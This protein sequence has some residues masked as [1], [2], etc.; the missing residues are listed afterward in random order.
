MKSIHQMASIAVKIRFC[1]SPKVCFWSGVRLVRVVVVA[2]FAC[3]QPL[4]AI[5]YSKL[6]MADIKK[7]AKAGDKDAQY[8]LGGLYKLGVEIPKDEDAAKYW[9]RKAAEQG[10]YSAWVALGDKRIAR[11]EPPFSLPSSPENSPAGSQLP[12]FTAAAISEAEFDFLAGTNPTR[13]PAQN[14][15]ERYLERLKW[16]NRTYFLSA[17]YIPTH[18]D[19]D[20]LRRKTLALL[21]LETSE[22]A[23]NVPPVL[24]RHVYEGI[25]FDIAVQKLWDARLNAN[26]QIAPGL[27][28]TAREVINSSGWDEADRAVERNLFDLAYKYFQLA[29][30]W[31]GLKALKARRDL[32]TSWARA[33]RQLSRDGEIGQAGKLYAENP[34]VTDPTWQFIADQ[35]AGDA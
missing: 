18:T 11:P 23:K 6:S 28:K 2:F 8:A 4:L 22:A 7:A 21:E 32:H 17:I 5:D 29:Q 19:R 16:I 13:T 26:D 35:G 31:D 9:Y 3:V 15:T 30:A 33:L 34:I 20:M 24:R 27:L 10:H 14:A 12:T 1:R 25:A